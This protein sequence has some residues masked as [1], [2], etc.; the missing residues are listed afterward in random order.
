MVT[1]FVEITNVSA[2][3]AAPDDS[4]VV[5]PENQVP[6]DDNPTAPHVSRIVVHTPDQCFLVAEVDVQLRSRDEVLSLVKRNL[7]QAQTRM[8]SY[9]DKHHSS[10]GH[11]VPQ[12]STLQ[13]TIYKL[14]SFH[15]LSSKYYG[16]FAVLERVG[17]VAYKLKLPSTVKIHNLFHVSLLKKMVGSF[18]TVEAAL[19]VIKDSSSIKWAP[20]FVLETRMVKRRNAVTT[21]WKVQWLGT[22]SE[23][24][25]WE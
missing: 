24:A 18:A 8:K 7:S 11:G 13:A 22:S 10:W 1:G 2:T 23:E 6:E 20:A 21:Q 25:T 19:P 5:T 16:P 12:D 14:K 4:G 17:E 3:Q 15:K 9:Y